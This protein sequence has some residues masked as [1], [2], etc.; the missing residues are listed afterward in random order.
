MREDV[1]PVVG[2]YLPQFAA[3]ITKAK[4][5]VC[6]ATCRFVLKRCFKYTAFRNPMSRVSWRQ[7][8]YECCALLLDR[9]ET[10]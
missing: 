7:Y 3:R 5:G 9:A 6:T 10:V 4:A 2:Q 8:G 1:A